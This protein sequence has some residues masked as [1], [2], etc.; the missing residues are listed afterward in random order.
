MYV[1]N[2]VHNWWAVSNPLPL[3]PC[4]GW[5]PTG[6]YI[7]DFTFLRCQ[8]RSPRY[9]SPIFLMFLI[10]SSF[11]CNR[12]F[13]GRKNSS[14]L[15]RLNCL[16]HLINSSMVISVFIGQETI[17]IWKLCFWQWLNSIYQIRSGS[18]DSLT[19]KDYYYL[20]VS[21][22]ALTGVVWWIM[23]TWAWKTFQFPL[24]KWKDRSVTVRV[25]DA[26]AEQMIAGRLSFKTVRI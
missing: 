10:S 24:W 6:D 23:N 12:S 4:M 20:S 3:P 8:T 7:R 19:K 26:Y 15:F 17:H 18:R 14:F 22:K 21:Q 5:S 25:C 11:P 9:E 16:L 13:G 1:I 2:S